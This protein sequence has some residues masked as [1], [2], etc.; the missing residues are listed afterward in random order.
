[1]ILKEVRAQKGP[2][3]T[4]PCGGSELAVV[5]GGAGRDRGLQGLRHASRT[6]G[7]R[8]LPF[9]QGNPK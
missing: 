1:V 4:S 5:R 3:V 2:T 7:S 9:V 8:R 6:V